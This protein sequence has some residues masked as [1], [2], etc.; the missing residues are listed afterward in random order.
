MANN[1]F[2]EF[3]P[4]LETI[5][6]LIASHDMKKT[7]KEAIKTF[8]EH[9]FDGEKFYANNMGVFEKYV[10]EF[11]NH[12]SLSE[13]DTFF[14]DSNDSDFIAVLSFLVIPNRDL[15]TSIDEID[16]SEIYKAL[17]EIC[18]YG[19]GMKVDFEQFDSLDDIISFLDTSDFQEGDKWKMMRLMQSPKKYIKQFINI[20]NSNIKAYEKAEKSIRAE[21]S[22][23]L[24][25]YYESVTDKDNG[26]FLKL[27]ESLTE[28][29]NIYPTLAL[30]LSQ[31]VFED[32]CYYGLF[33]SII[34]GEESDKKSKEKLIYG[35]K[36]LSDKSKLQILQS[37]KKSPK[38]NLEIANELELTA[39]TMSHHMNVLLT[40]GFV[41]VDKK[42]GRVYY[43]LEEES[44][45]L[46]LDA[47][48]KVLL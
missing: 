29:A 48:Q 15:I 37:L 24:E 43:H 30:P 7:K 34:L 3:D 10:K 9:G 38:Y 35:L 22:K 28:T 45:R 14:F 5:G 4:F 39:P 23:L 13:K 27:K 26:Q 25:K 46:F 16:N 17:I 8:N 21:L 44:I 40:C 12:C 47:L 2:K 19:L 18:E 31:L 6:L 36:A 42:N 32:N 1:I 20:I 11:K 41:G 33:A